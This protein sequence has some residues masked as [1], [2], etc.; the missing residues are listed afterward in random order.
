MKNSSSEHS[1]KINR[2]AM[3]DSENESRLRSTGRSSIATIPL[4]EKIII[5]IPKREF[6]SIEPIRDKSEEER[7]REE[8]CN[9]YRFLVNY[10]VFESNF[11]W[12]PFEVRTI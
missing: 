12:L 6:T 1:K 5:P 3:K 11:E 2:D 9:S 7:L 8:M 10:G 4:P